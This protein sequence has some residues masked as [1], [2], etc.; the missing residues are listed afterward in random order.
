MGFLE[1]IGNAKKKYD[2][3]EANEKQKTYD[4][5]NNRLLYLEQREKELKGR[6]L[7]KNKE[8]RVARME[9]RLQPKQSKRLGDPFGGPSLYG[10][11][12]VSTDDYFSFGMPAKKGK[13]KSGGSSDDMFRQVWGV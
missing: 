1:S 9:R 11:G 5:R 10:G 6:V 8:D 12:R 7:L 3:W 4:R 2:S 13:R